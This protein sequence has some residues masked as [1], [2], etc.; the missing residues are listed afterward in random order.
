LQ[1]TQG[2]GTEVERRDHENR[3]RFR[4]SHINYAEIPAI[5]GLPQRY[6]GSVAAQAVLER[7]PE[8]VVNFLL[9]NIVT[10]DVWLAGFRIDVEAEFHSKRA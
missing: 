5:A 9:G 8:N 1:G 6:P 10:M 2:F 7:S 3:V 4:I